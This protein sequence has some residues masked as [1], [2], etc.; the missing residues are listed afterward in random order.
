MKKVLASC[1]VAVLTA[2]TLGTPMASA[3][4]NG[5]DP[6]DLV[7]TS[8]T[9]A[10]HPL[11]GTGVVN[12]IFDTHDHGNYV[13]SKEGD[14]IANY[15]GIIDQIKKQNPSSVYV[16]NGDDMGTSTLS[17]I[18]QGQNMI[19]AYNAGPL[20]TDT[21]GNH[22]FDMGPQRLRQL[23]SESKFQWVSSNVIDKTTGK[24]FG[25]AEGVKPFIIKDINGVKVGITGVTNYDAPQLTSMGTS[26][27]VEDPATALNAIIP[28]MK[29]AGA[30]VIIVASH[31]ASPDARK[32]VAKV[33]GIDLLVGDH[34]AF[35]YDRP[36]QINHTLLWFIGDQFRY[37]GDVELKV[38]PSGVVDFNYKR[39]TTADEAAKPGFQPDP[40]VQ[41]L[42]DKYN[43]ELTQKL[44]AVVGKTTVPLDAIEADVRGKE[45]NLGD[46]IT[47][48]MR[49]SM[50]ADVALLNGGSIRTDSIF[51]PGTL[52][53]QDVLNFLPFTNYEVKIA[54]SGQ[55]LYDALENGVSQVSQQAG[56]FL[57]VSG[58]TYSFNPSLPVGH[59]IIN[60]T[61]GGKPL[62]LK[63]NY[64][65]AT[66]DYM[67]GGGDG[68]TM[69]K[70]AK[71]LIPA[72]GGPLM[73][74]VLMK[75]VAAQGTIAP[76]TD[77]RIQLTTATKSTVGQAPQP[78]P[79]GTSKS[80]NVVYTVQSGDTLW[81]LG[82]KYHVSWQSIAAQNHLKNPNL[83][84]IG[85]KLNIPS[86]S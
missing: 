37:V 49:T 39:Y 85:E 46:Y 76:K 40:A 57:Q 31:L 47:D 72:N 28:K 84:L 53:K 2:L 6:G 64:T 79:S 83:I 17:S 45:S 5:T 75:Q 62:D 65:V 9:A 11:S 59:R 69:F 43:A 71:V 14:N 36:E 15:F 4:T 51:Q 38:G 54:V 66:N 74:D 23:I 19:D 1:S 63:A 60:V 27:T 8:Y 20:D 29:A 70:D 68:Y 13:G 58:M 12:I 77:G 44:G 61:V 73:S 18:T 10:T 16:G 55:I 81:A 22:D 32:V 67:L 52:T 78:S 24:T 86:H 21:F 50:H 48:T 80:S 41:A 33:N 3:T 56:R 34:A 82:I 26:V 25:E 35:A 7:S 30:Q 42:M